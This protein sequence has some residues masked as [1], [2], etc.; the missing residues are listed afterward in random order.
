MVQ[1]LEKCQRLT[2]QVV[3]EVVGDCIIKEW[4]RQGICLVQEDLILDTLQQNWMGRSQPSQMPHKD[5]FHN[6]LQTALACGHYLVLN[7]M[8]AVRNWKLYFDQQEHIAG[9]RWWMVTVG[10]VSGPG[11]SRSCKSRILRHLQG[12]YTKWKHRHRPQCDCDSEGANAC[13]IMRTS[14]TV[15]PALRLEHVES[16]LRAQRLSEGKKEATNFEDTES[17]KKQGRG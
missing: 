9:A 8:Y 12:S 14:P 3:T 1:V 16:E 11:G 15:L 17:T 10:Q 13:P 5:S 7:S 6:N 2:V 4:K